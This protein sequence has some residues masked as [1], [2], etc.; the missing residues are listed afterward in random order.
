[1]RAAIYGEPEAS[2]N[3]DSQGLNK[4]TRII[5]SLTLADLDESRV[6]EFQSSFRVGCLHVGATPSPL[7][8]RAP[9]LRSAPAWSPEHQPG[10]VSSQ[11]VE[12]DTSQDRRLST[13]LSHI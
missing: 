11:I 2:E 10:M 1:M 3:G 13:G 9:T 5:A 7:S 6:F 4:C 12:L 8:L